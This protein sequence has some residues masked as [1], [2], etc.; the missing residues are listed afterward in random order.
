[1]GTNK[2]LPIQEVA[3]KLELA[4][5]FRAQNLINGPYFG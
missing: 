5:V 3:N 2:E 4:T 1:M